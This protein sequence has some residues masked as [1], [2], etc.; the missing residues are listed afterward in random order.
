MQCPQCK[1]SI[2][3]EDAR[4]CPGCGANLSKS[5]PN[6]RASEL[7]TPKRTADQKTPADNV[8]WEGTFAAK[9][10]AGTVFNSLAISVILTGGIVWFWNEN[11]LRWTGMIL[12]ALVWLYVTYLFLDERIGTRYRLTP[13]RFYH[14][15]G[16]FMHS[17]DWIE[18]LYV[19]DITVRQTLLERI[20]GVGSITILSSDESH[21]KLVIRGIDHVHQVAELF[22][23]ARYKQRAERGIHVESI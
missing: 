16:L 18:L 20:L 23:D 12:F 5:S 19:D 3:A 13:I 15:E 1:Y 22:R 21:P 6:E 9:G 2:E 7:F 17:T 8:I 4:F 10:L 14:E 11:P